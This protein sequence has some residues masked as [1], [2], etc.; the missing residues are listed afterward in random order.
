MPTTNQFCAEISWMKETGI[1]T[2][3]PEGTYRPTSPVARQAMSAFLFR[4]TLVVP[5][6]L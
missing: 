4:Y 5:T 1:S 6:E 3:D 2:G